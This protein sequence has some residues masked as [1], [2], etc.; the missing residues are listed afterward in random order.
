MNKAL[1]LDRDGVI[2]IDKSYVYK[3]KDFEFLSDIFAVLRLAQ[4]KHYLL[5]VVTNQSGIARGFYSTQDFERLTA[6]ML[7]EFS[8]RDIVINK[9]YHCPH[10]QKDNCACRK[11]RTQMLEQAKMD[12]DI[13]LNQ[14]LLVGDKLSDIQ[15]AHN[16]GVKSI[17]LNNK[18]SCEIADLNITKLKD[19]I[20]YL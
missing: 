17:F 14:S 20:Q 12:F 11:P 8:K 7:N 15:C 13:D 1:F 10:H 3:I 19:L 2:N 16:L 9:V 6:F 18:S 5:I 4:A